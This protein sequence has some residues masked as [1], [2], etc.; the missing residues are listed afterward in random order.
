[1]NWQAMSG[2]AAGPLDQSVEQEGAATMSSHSGTP[3]DDPLEEVITAR[4]AAREKGVHPVSIYRAIKEGRLKGSRSG[5]T[6]L[7]R[8]RDL[9]AWQPVGHRPGNEG[10]L[11]PETLPANGGT[12]E[13][14][15][16]LM[17]IISYRER[18][19]QGSVIARTAGALKSRQ[20]PETAEALRV[21]AEQAFAAE[22]EERQ[23]C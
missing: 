4:V 19:P 23:G 11:E 2:G 13:E 18:F 7:I 21:I 5:H 14:E 3:V 22:A 8:R 17:Q 15:A 12:T 1:V 9:A 10:R 20:A 16:R 6:I